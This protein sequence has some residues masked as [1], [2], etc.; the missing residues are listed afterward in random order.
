MELIK[1]TKNPRDIRFSYT[2]NSEN[3]DPDVDVEEHSAK[4]HDKPLPS[5]DKAFS[6]LRLVLAKKLEIPDPASYAET[7]Q[8]VGLTIR[9]TKAGTRS[10]IVHGK[11][12]LST[13]RSTLLKMDSPL[14]QIDKQAAGESGE[15]EFEP[16]DLKVVLKAIEEAE[17]YANGERAQGRLQLDAEVG[18]LAKKGADGP[19]LFGEE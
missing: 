3:E 10:V 12:E 17:K 2:T 8:V 6:A 5:L 16:K 18:A 11:K 15:V 13:R 9:R 4:C 14:L 7:L 19:S 1:L